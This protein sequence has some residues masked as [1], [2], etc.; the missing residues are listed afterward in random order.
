[1]FE[2]EEAVA[3]YF[4]VG[5]GYDYN[6]AKRLIRWLDSCGYALVPKDQAGASDDPVLQSI[7]TQS[8][9]LRAVIAGAG[10]RKSA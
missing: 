4:P 8:M 5:T 7:D 3:R 10:R 9:S 2:P 6:Q 1:M